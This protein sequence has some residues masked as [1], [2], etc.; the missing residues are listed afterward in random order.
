MS[1]AYTNNEMLENYKNYQLSHLTNTHLEQIIPHLDVE[2][3]K[4][5]GY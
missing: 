1:G 5:L 3:L 2:L 4:K